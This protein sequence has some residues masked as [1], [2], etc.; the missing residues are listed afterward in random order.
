M[1]TMI[2]SCKVLNKIIYLPW[3]ARHLYYCLL[4]N[5]ICVSAGFIIL[6]TVGVYGTRAWIKF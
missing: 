4:L 1:E 5:N 2:I 6:S 3:T